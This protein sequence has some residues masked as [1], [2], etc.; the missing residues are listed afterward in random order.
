MLRE[1]GSDAAGALARFVEIGRAEDTAPEE[2]E[3]VFVDCGA[4]GFHQ[5]ERKRVAA[6]GVRVNDSDAGAGANLLA[7]DLH[8]LGQFAED[9]LGNSLGIRG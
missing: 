8:R 2:R 6:P 4:G 9:T 3:D 7:A 1:R 5:V